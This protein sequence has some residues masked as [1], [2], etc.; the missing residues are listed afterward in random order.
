MAGGPGRAG[1]GGYKLFGIIEE[2]RANLLIS[3]KIGRT[4]Q[5]TLF[6]PGYLKSAE[7][8]QEDGVWYPIVLIFKFTDCI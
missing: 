6:Q 5:M 7:C 4:K 8:S 3:W 1:A 2:K